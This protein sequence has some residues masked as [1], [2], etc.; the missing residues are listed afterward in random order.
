MSLVYLRS[1]ATEKGRMVAA[2]D[3]ECMGKTFREG[4]LKLSLQTGF[5]G[6]ALFGIG[7]ALALLDRAEILNL[8]GPKIVEAAIAR[9]LVHPEAVISIGGVPHVQVMKL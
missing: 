8:V 6:S 2:C 9:G 3:E 1:Y 7:E 4:R 5:Y